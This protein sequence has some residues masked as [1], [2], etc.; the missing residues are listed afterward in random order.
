MFLING[1]NENNQ[2]YLGIKYWEELD[3]AKKEIAEKYKNA[4]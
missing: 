4:K 3:D 1:D 2:L